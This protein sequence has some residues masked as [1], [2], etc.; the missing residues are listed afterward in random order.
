[1]L[2]TRAP[3]R[4]DL[5]GLSSDSYAAGA[6]VRSLDIGNGITP[7]W[8]GGGPRSW[9]PW[10]PRPRSGRQPFLAAAFDLETPREAFIPGSLDDLDLGGCAIEGRLHP[11][12]YERQDTVEWVRQR[13]HIRRL[14]LRETLWYPS[15]DGFVL[16]DCTWEGLRTSQKPALVLDGCSFKHLTLK[17]FIGRLWIR[18]RWDQSLP[19]RRADTPEVDR[20]LNAFYDDVDWALDIREAELGFFDISGVPV[21]KIRFDPETAAILRREQADHEKLLKVP[22]VEYTG[23]PNDAMVLRRTRFPACLLVAS[24]RSKDFDYCRRA[25]AAL[26]KAKLV[27]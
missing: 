5:P 7:V 10:A 22:H 8:R 2:A 9:Q 20:A 23:F 4:G 18:E 24:R 25:I 13:P 17:G 21:E 16:E 26:R 19:E 12:G 11:F 15:F 27:E 3:R 6:M 1:M 14:V